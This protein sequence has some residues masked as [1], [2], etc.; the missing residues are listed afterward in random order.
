MEKENFYQQLTDTIE[1]NNK[2]DILLVLGDLNA[3][4]GK[5]NNGEES[6]MGVHGIDQKQEWRELILEN[7]LVIAGTIFHPKIVKK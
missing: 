4:V 3:K 6:C 7:N 5:D 1:N 2:G